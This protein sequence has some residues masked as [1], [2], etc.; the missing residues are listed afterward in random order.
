MSPKNLIG[1]IGFDD[2][3]Y[4][5]LTSKSFAIIGTILALFLIVAFNTKNKAEEKIPVILTAESVKSV[6]KTSPPPCNKFTQ[7]F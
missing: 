6:T 3:D 2:A 5:D 1:Y 4:A 7:S